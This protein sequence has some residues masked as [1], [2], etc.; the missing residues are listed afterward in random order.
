[1]MLRHSDLQEVY[2]VAAGGPSG[3]RCLSELTATPHDIGGAL[4]RL[5]MSLPA[6][7]PGTV[8]PKSLGLKPAP[9]GRTELGLRGH[10][11]QN[12]LP[13]VLSSLVLGRDSSAFRSPLRRPPL[14]PRARAG[15]RSTLLGL[16]A[17]VRRLVAQEEMRGVATGPVITVVE[18]VRIV[19]D[20][21]DVDLV[22]RA[23]SVDGDYATTDGVAVNLAVAP[24]VG[25]PGERPAPVRWAIGEFGVKSLLQCSSH[26]EGVPPMH[27]TSSFEIADPT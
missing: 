12:S 10:A 6:V 5:T 23:V 15:L 9:T 22:R 17:H 1:M 20:R 8:A 7:A 14:G 19:G 21:P 16:V 3:P 13:L 4:A 27:G 18:D 25:R 11:C 2:L 26:K 24:R